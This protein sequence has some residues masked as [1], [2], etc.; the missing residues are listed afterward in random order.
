MIKP[1]LIMALCVYIFALLCLIDAYLETFAVFT[2][3]SFIKHFP[4]VPGFLTS[5]KPAPDN[6][7]ITVPDDEPAPDEVVD[8]SLPVDVPITVPDDEPAPDGT[9]VPITVPDDEPAPDEVV[10]DDSLPVDEPAPD[11]PPKPASDDPQICDPDTLSKANLSCDE[12]KKL[13]KLHNDR[14]SAHGSPPLKWDNAVARTVG[15]ALRTHCEFSHVGVPGGNI[16]AGNPQDPKPQLADYWY[17]YE[18]CNYNFDDPDASTGPRGHLTQMLWKDNTTFGCAYVGPEQC[19]DGIYDPDTKAKTNPV[20]LSCKY[21]PGGN[22]GGPAV[23]KSNVRP[24][25]TGSLP[26]SNGRYTG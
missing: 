23:Y 16:S 22:G 25:S 19:P 8:D 10:D 6:V 1:M 18:I 7:P 26:C 4:S 9:D 21:N 15:D 20:L 14:R 2:H 5:T 11:L 24:L 17:T 3:P 13:I 12:V